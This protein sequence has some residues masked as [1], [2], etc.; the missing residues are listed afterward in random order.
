MKS[1][2]DSVTKDI[3]ANNLAYLNP[4]VVSSAQIRRLI[5]RLVKNI[6]ASG[7][8]NKENVT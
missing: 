3:I 8:E 4:K 6:Q 5:E 1:D 2:I 7:L